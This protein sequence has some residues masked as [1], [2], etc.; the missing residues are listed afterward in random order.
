MYDGNKNNKGR[1]CS[2]ELRSSQRG[3]KI[4]E[5]NTG[6]GKESWSRGTGCSV[7][8][9]TA[10]SSNEMILS[11][12]HF[13]SVTHSTLFSHLGPR[14]ISFCPGFNF[15]RFQSQSQETHQKPQRPNWVDPAD[16]HRSTWP[17]SIYPG[18]TG[19]EWPL[20]AQQPHTANVLAHAMRWT[21]SLSTV[22]L[23]LFVLLLT[24]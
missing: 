8:P 14:I 18:S 12:L 4:Q 13:L 7:V 19:C 5:C 17:L 23:K 15:A 20:G 21:F 16:R 24:P 10:E 22:F 6:K 2:K 11:N 9:Y 1:E 3:K